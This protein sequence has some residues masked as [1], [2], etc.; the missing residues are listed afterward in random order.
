MTTQ[1]KSE[2]LA[3]ANSDKIKILSSFFKTGPGQYGEGDR[4]IG[5]TVP[6]NRAIAKHY[7]HLPYPAIKEML[8][9]EIHE[10]RLSGFLALAEKY[11]KALTNEERRETVDFYLDNAER[12]NNWDLVDLSAPKILG[13][14][15]K[16]NPDAQL[17]HTLHAD[18]CM[19]RTRISIVSTYTLIKSGRYEE[20]L[21]L[22]GKSFNHPHELIHKATGWM[23]HE[24]GKKDQNALCSFLDR[25]AAAMPRT[26]LRYAIE[27]LPEQ[28]R[29]HYMQKR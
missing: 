17:L 12:A 15:L 5:V 3:A 19:W 14:W 18:D 1:W 22:A 7:S 28:Q 2:L 4:F 8:E 13:E 6:Q 23:L 26:M 16:R 10:F 24:V 11:R 21:T 9:S 20:I 27:R 25:H 29:R